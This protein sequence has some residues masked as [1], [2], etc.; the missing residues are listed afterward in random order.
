[1]LSASVRVS[2][3]G[4]RKGRAVAAARPSQKLHHVSD[5]TDTTPSLQLQCLARY[6]VTGIRAGLI[7]SL[8]WGTDGGN[9]LIGGVA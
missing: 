7:A 4:K 2:K 1:M 6:G 9:A 8:I 3:P 5:S